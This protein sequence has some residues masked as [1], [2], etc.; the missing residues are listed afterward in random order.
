MTWI[1]LRLATNFGSFHY[2]LKAY[3]QNSSSRQDW[4]NLKLGAYT[5]VLSWPYTYTAQTMWLSSS[6][7][8]TK[9]TGNEP[10]NN[11]HQHRKCKLSTNYHVDKHEE[12]IFTTNHRFNQLQRD[13]QPKSIG[14][15]VIGS[16]WPQLRRGPKRI[17]VLL[18]IVLRCLLK[19]DWRNI[20]DILG[21]HA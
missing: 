1:C 15:L 11:W 8:R 5:Y 14:C 19:Q 17:A 3:W 7:L 2:A 4:L 12:T 18:G 16:M 10:N 13:F 21:N 20:S 6:K 9:R